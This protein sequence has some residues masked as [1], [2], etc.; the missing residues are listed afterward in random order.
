[1]QDCQRRDEM[2]FERFAQAGIPV[3][4]AMGGGYSED[5]KVVVQ[6]HMN[7]FRAAVDAWT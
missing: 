2:I 7:T 6:A 5:V 1:M 4:C 3:V